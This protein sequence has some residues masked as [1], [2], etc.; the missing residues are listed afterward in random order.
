M[1]RKSK[2]SAAE[3]SAL[4]ARLRALGYT[5]TQL[6]AII[7]AGVTRGEI[8]D[9]IIALQRQSARAASHQ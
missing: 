4:V 2:P 7:R 9:G 1:D 8:A 3:R 6:A 5:G